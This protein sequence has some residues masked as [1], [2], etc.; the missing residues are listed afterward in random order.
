MI[1]LIDADVLCHK[2]AFINEYDID[3]GEGIASKQT[4]R[5]KALA[6]LASYVEH[7]LKVSNC[8]EA[9]LVLSGSNNF[10]YSVLPTYKHHRGEK[11]ELVDV[12]KQ[13]IREFYP[14]K[15]KDC[16]EGDDVMGIMMTNEPDKYVCCTIDKDLR[17]IPGTHFHMTNEEFFYVSEDEG[18]AFFFTQ[19]L[20]GDA[21]DGYGGCPGVGKQGAGR[22]IESPYLLV[23]YEHTFKAGPRK[24]QTEVRYKEEPTDDLWAAIVSQYEAKGLTE[25]EALQQARVAK[26][27]TNKEWDFKKEEVKLWTPC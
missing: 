2:F 24:G 14:F 1:L 9:I 26:I 7:L 10:R 21:T 27:L 6:D 5:R 13:H 12:L 16:L 20:T 18:N 4:N 19:V 23:P 8:K 3:W 17:Q 25:A 22:L 15:E 11:P